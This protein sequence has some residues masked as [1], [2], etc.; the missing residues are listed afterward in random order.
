MNENSFG[1]KPFGN[2]V[3][4]QPEKETE[5][6]ASGLFR[7]ANSENESMKGTVVAVGPGEEEALPFTVGTKVLFRKQY[8]ATEFE[9]DNQT[10]L[11]LRKDDLIGEITQ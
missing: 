4:I 2:Q 11:V 1:I 3:I 7:P 9:M 10:Y 6:T 8:A 5:K